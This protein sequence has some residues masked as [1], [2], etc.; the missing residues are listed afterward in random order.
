M[1]IRNDLGDAWSITLD[2][3]IADDYV[4]TPWIDVEDDLV[5]VERIKHL[6]IE[7]FHAMADGS[8][9][10][11]VTKNSTPD[12]VYALTG[13][14][15]QCEAQGRDVIVAFYN[16]L[17]GMSG[18]WGRNT[19][20]WSN[21]EIVNNS[22]KVTV[23][24]E[25]TVKAAAGGESR[26]PRNY[27]MW[28]SS[29]NLFTRV[30]QHV[31]ASLGPD[32]LAPFLRCLRLAQEDVLHK[33]SK[34]SFRL[35]PSLLR[36]VES[37][38]L[39]PHL[40][41]EEYGGGWDN[42]ATKG[43]ATDAVMKLISHMNEETFDEWTA[44]HTEPD[45]VFSGTTRASGRQELCASY[46]S[47]VE[48][49]WGSGAVVSWEDA[50][51]WIQPGK[52]VCRAIERVEKEG[53]G[54][55]AKETTYAFALSDANKV[56][57]ITRTQHP[58]RGP[59]PPADGPRPQGYKLAPDRGST[60]NASDGGCST[61]PGQATAKVSQQGVISDARSELSEGSPPRTGQVPGAVLKPGVS[62]GA[63]LQQEARADPAGLSVSK[64]DSEHLN[65]SCT[66]S[67]LVDDEQS[68]DAPDRNEPHEIDEARKA[69]AGDP[70]D[71]ASWTRPCSHNAWDS[72]RM[73]RSWCLLRCRECQSRWKVKTAGLPRLRCKAYS[74]G[75]CRGEACTC[76]HIFERKQRL[77]ER[78]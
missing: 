35:D 70:S 39:V 13:P 5:V 19:L 46:N 53:E 37:E 65:S 42:A 50:E 11:W 10:V 20:M 38:R 60:G 54:D 71:M 47:L 9:V 52:G 64:T 44:R 24:L 12:I 49:E 22:G 31:G 55:E 34:C 61:E 16:R 48:T 8:F 56:K 68:K 28:L 17:V 62:I 26:I 3:N 33:R 7:M 76:L 78:M 29:D 51:F 23:L 63:R 1:V 73:K 59:R 77:D 4:P 21:M 30:G 36:A 58:P 41:A 66:G 18:P 2:T 25:E 74:S 6:L 69:S 40:P 75:S 72:V 45:V 15:V 14:S 32:A 43:W 27:F 57:T 67:A